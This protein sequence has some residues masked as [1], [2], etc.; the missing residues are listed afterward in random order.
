MDMNVMTFL[1]T[2][3]LFHV[4]IAIGFLLFNPDL[5]KVRIGVVFRILMA[6]FLSFGLS[7]A[8]FYLANRF[9]WNYV[10]NLLLYLVM[11]F[12]LIFDYFLIFDCSFKDALLILTLCYCVQHIAYQTIYLVYD[13]WIYTIV[14]TATTTAYI[15]LNSINFLLQLFV[16]FLIA[17]VLRGIF[18]R[19]YKYS[20]T[21]YK[22]FVISTVTLIIVLALNTLTLKLASW[23]VPFSIISS[24]FC[25][26]C[27]IFILLLI[28]GFF[29]KNKYRDERLKMEMYYQEKLKQ[30]A[31]SQEAIEYINIKC[32]DLR[33]KIRDFKN[34]KDIL[35]ESEI[36][37]IANAIRIYDETYQTGN[38]ILDHI[39]LSKS[40]TLQKNGIELT[41][42][43]DGKA[44][45]I[46]TKSD[47]I[48][49]FTNV[50]DNAIEATRKIPERQNRYI[51][52]IVKTRSGFLYIEETN[53]YVS[54]VEIKDD[55]LLS[56]KR[57]K[58]FNGFGTK[59][60]AMIIRNH[61]GRVSYQADGGVFTIRILV[62]VAK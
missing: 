40:I 52:L 50:L 3:V 5:K 16:D 56:T 54:K 62:P 36:D 24:L 11:F 15:I 53:P 7:Y 45:G 37:N 48:S 38:E 42:M 2:V 25:I 59:S 30:Y 9:Y 28:L 46:F 17:F 43:C 39:L 23:Y 8:F 61:G 4:E 55:F 34:N 21:S 20:I 6:I 57:N 26:L 58:Y 14:P 13:S 18:K 60:I 10:T 47:L 19:N 44:L 33:K 35:D 51:S 41:T 29:E 27:C 12:T 22:V 32:H 31:M 49:L 1:S